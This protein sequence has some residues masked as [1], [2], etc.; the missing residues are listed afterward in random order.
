[1]PLALPLP[2]PSAAPN[3]VLGTQTRAS[4][5]DPARF[6]NVRRSKFTCMGSTALSTGEEVGEGAC[7]GQL[8]DM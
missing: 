8:Q 1:M 7:T 4:F 6:E 3:P 5:W 2:A